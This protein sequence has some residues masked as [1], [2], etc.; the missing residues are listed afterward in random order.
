LRLAWLDVL[1]IDLSPVSPGL[2]LAADVLRT[3]VAPDRQGLAA[4][5]DHLLQASDH[6]LDLSV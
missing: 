6:T 5:L 4:P 2:E 1:D 3:V